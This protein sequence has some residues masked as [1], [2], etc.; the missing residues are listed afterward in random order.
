MD[1]KAH[2]YHGMYDAYDTH[3]RILIHIMLCGLVDEGPC[4]LGND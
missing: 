4:I 1:V 2:I 3:V